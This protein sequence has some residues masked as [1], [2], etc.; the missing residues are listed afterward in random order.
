MTLNGL[1]IGTTHSVPARVPSGRLGAYCS[2]TVLAGSLTS[3]KCFT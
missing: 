1:G 3:G 2:S